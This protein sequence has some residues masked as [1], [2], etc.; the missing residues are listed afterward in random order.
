MLARQPLAPCMCFFLYSP[1]VRVFG[2][3]VLEVLIGLLLLFLALSVVCSGIKEIAASFFALR[4]RTLE[5]AIRKMLHEINGDVAQNLLRHPLIAGTVSPDKK[6]PSYISS[7]NFALALVD[8][9]SPQNDGT[10][11]RT[12]SDLRASIVN[13]P[14]TNLRKTL[15]GFIDTAQGDMDCALKKIE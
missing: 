11:T 14:A 12:I 15:L 9:I 5:T 3:Q 13:L 4:S 6:L 1:E 2:S 8:T 10:Q 7:R